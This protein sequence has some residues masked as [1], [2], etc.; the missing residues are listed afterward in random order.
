MCAA[1]VAHGTEHVENARLA[2]RTLLDRSS[3]PNGNRRT[4]LRC[5]SGR[6]VARKRFALQ[7]AQRRGSA[8]LERRATV[9]TA[10]RS[11]PTTVPNPENNSD[12]KCGVRGPSYA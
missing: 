6:I 11:T 2:H 12:M 7:E 3:V 4:V 8:R 9:R 1:D 10:A 5:T